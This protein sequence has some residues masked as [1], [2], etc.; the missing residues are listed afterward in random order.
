MIHLLHCP[1]MADLAARISDQRPDVQ[2]GSVSWN[3]FRDGFPDLLVENAK[4]L[5]NRDV[6]C[7]ASLGPA[8]DH[9]LR[10][11][12]TARAAR[13]PRPRVPSLD[14][15]GLSGCSNVSGLPEAAGIKRLYWLS[16]PLLI[17]VLP[18]FFIDLDRWIGAVPPEVHALG[19]V[20]FFG[21]LALV[22]MALPPL[23]RR[24]FA[25]RAVLVLLI[26]LVVGS[27]VEVAQ[28]FLGRSPSLRDVAL[29]LVGAMAAVSLFARPGVQRRVFV[30]LAGTLLVAM[31]AAPALD[32][33]DRAVAR[34]QFPTLAE[35]DTPLEH[36]RWS[37]G[38][39]S[40]TIARAGSRSLRIE[41]APGSWPSFGTHMQRSFGDWS[42]YGYLE[43]SLFNPD[44]EPLRLGLSIRDREHFRSG[45]SYRN[46]YATR[47]ELDWGWNDVRIPVAE[48]RDG[49]EERPLDLDQIAELAIFAL[50]LERPRVVFLDRVRLVE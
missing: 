32:L 26:I 18:L 43:L 35:F 2:L 24:Q 17:G 7:L 39:P 29:N 12:R 10:H 27:A 25:Q 47:M 16:V 38:Q 49:P 44:D 37:N 11:P 22:L 13:R 45:R 6:V 28:G 40:E 23:R 5:R 8:A 3:A 21:V 42:G 34:A 30:G 20:A 36:R 33:A 31:L 50:D 1:Q 15:R 4:S 14:G 46:R 41:L 19:H 48:I 9:H